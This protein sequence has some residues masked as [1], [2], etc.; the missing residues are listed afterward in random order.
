VTGR[1]GGGDKG[2]EARKLA[3]KQ[4]KKK[5]GGAVNTDLSATTQLRDLKLKKRTGET[6]DTSRSA[7]FRKCGD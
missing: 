1:E 6:G 2:K 7:G 3:K 4:E 5:K